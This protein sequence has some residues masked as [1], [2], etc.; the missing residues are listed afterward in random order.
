M[1]QLTLKFNILLQKI[2]KLGVPVVA[3]QKRIQRVSMR[4][5]VPFLASL[6][7]L[8]IRRC[9][10]LWCKSQTP[11]GFCI[12]WLAAVALIWPLSLGTSKCRGCGPVKQK[13]KRQKQKT[14]NKKKPKLLKA[15]F[16]QKSFR[17]K[18][19]QSGHHL[20]STYCVS[21]R[22]SLWGRYYL[23]I[24]QIRRLRK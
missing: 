7:G 10:E 20:L 24:S 21:S 1:L 22:T 6:S 18:I 9:R 16:H 12:L 3:Q 5:R 14:K 19:I 11:L 4:M 15:D 8:R 23:S 17:T 13:K 2:P